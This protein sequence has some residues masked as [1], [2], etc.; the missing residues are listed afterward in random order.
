MSSLYLFP[1]S[2][3]RLQEVQWEVALE[4][5]TQVE[6]VPVT[7]SSPCFAIGRDT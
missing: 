7:G 6:E 4:A 3:L 5:K 2:W 1:M